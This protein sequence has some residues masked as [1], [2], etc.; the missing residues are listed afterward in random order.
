MGVLLWTK[1]GGGHE[2]R[3]PCGL[4]ENGKRNKYVYIP[5]ELNSW[6]LDIP[7]I[8]DGNIYTPTRMLDI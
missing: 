3:V 7:V 2:V 4:S 6:D 8:I 1:G 5:L